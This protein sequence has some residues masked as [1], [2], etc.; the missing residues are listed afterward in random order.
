MEYNWSFSRILKGPTMLNARS[1]MVFLFGFACGA[2]ISPIAIFYY[3]MKYS[4]Q[5][6][7]TWPHDT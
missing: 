2:V 4:K 3:L 6:E 5:D 1:L 7:G